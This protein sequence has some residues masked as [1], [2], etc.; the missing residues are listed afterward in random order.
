MGLYVHYYGRM[1]DKRHVPQFI[2][3]MSGIAATLKWNHKVWRED[4]AKPCD[5]RIEKVDGKPQMVGHLPVK[6]VTIQPSLV[7]EPMQF[8]IDPKGQLRSIRS[9]LAETRGEKQNPFVSVNL[10]GITS[11]VYVL[12]MGSLLYV[13]KHFVP[14]LIVKDEGGYWQTKDRSALVE[15][16][17]ESN[18]KDGIGDEKIEKAPPS[19]HN[20]SGE[21]VMFKLETIF[22]RACG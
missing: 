2:E 9:L 1:K 8:L 11:E 12:L 22:H 18:V 4:W 10:K 3:E 6:G 16:V 14:D 7:C 20:L 15:G 19:W 5:A 21:Q 13:Q 17:K